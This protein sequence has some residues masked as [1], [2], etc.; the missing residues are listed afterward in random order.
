[1]ET[2]IDRSLEARINLYY[3]LRPGTISPAPLLIAL[4]GYGANKRQMMREAQLMAPE[5][6]AIAAV[7]GFHQHIRDPR[8][9]GGPLRFGFGW[10]TNFKSDESVALHHRAMLDLIEILT[11]EGVADPSRIFLLG[12][13]QSCALNYRFAFTHPER[14]RGVVGIC[15]G[16]PGDWE[17]SPAYRQTQLDVFHLAGTRDE[18]YSPERVHD[19]ERQLQTRARSV[20][21]KSYNAAHDFVP[22]M[23]PDVVQWLTQTADEH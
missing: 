4:H 10:L 15:G 21:F 14:L 20:K 3:D 7:Q 16:I 22:E 17:T 2:Q 8:E 5:Q 23:R 19:Y 18:F 11:G 9:A 13:S 1:M 6:F 12:F